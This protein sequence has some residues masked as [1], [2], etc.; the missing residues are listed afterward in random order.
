MPDDPPD[1]PA[2][3]MR[4]SPLAPVLATYRA[5][6]SGL[7][8]EIWLLCFTCFVNRAGMMVL[9]FLTLFLTQDRA[10][11][12][13]AAGRLMAVYGIGSLV[14]SFAGGWLSDRIGSIRT[15]QL[16]LVGA[17]VGYL[18]VLLTQDLRW[19]ALVVFLTSVAADAFR[20]A[21]MAAVTRRAP[22]GREGRSLAL[23]RLATNLGMTVG[24][25]VG[26][27]LA[28][29]GYAWLFVAD[30]ATCWLAAILL[31]ILLRP[32]GRVGAEARPAGASARSPWADRP[33]VL[34]MVLVFVLASAF[35][36]VFSTLPIHYR[37]AYHFGESTIGMVLGLNALLVVL[38]EM[39]VMHRVERRERLP[40][41]A[42]GSVLVASGLAT[43]PLGSTLPFALFSTLL[44]TAGEILSLPLMNALVADR[45]PAGAQGAY[46][47]AYTMTFSAAFVVAPFAG[48]WAYEHYGP[49]L[50][51]LG[52]GLLSIPLLLGCALLR[53]ILRR[54]RQ[55]AMEARG[56]A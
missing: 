43:L 30:A 28:G 4:F 10:L 6:F 35:F 15:Q 20:P 29:L 14:G 53:G 48:T 1:T 11:G 27:F 23:L 44:W 51:W 8:R 47:G 2:S 33:F 7:P 9:P 34:L 38:F 54:E 41:I 45:A 31:Q 5:A 36:Q 40:L 17:G 12:V 37:A 19:L 13:A 18:T 16:S 42:V 26:G 21:V 46:M 22:A 49:E 39:V 50:L 24:P 52:V 25:A 32:R 55:L 3:P 56:A